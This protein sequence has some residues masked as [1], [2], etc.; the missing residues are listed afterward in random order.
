MS[1]DERAFNTGLSSNA[2]P[3]PNPTLSALGEGL[4]GPYR[5]LLPTP[6]SEGRRVWDSLPDSFSVGWGGTGN[7]CDTERC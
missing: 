3:H 7:L 4:P 1:D 5:T 2:G 6:H